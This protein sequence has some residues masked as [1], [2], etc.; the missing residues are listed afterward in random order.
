MSRQPASYGLEGP[1]LASQA[2]LGKTAAPRCRN[3]LP[4][5]CL[6]SLAA[7]LVLGSGSGLKTCMR[8]YTTAR[9][10]VS[11]SNRDTA[12]TAVPPDARRLFGTPLPRMQL[13]EGAQGFEPAAYRM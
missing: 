4:G 3:L 13:V 1:K 8:F 2:R 5:S 10:A 7:L 6:V 11:V 9:I 12:I